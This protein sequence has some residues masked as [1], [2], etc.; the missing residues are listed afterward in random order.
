MANDN[1]NNSRINVRFAELAKKGECALI[2]YVVAGYPDL[3]TSQ[4]VAEMLI[5]GGA[6]AIEI[7][8]PFSDPI[9]DGPTIQAASNASLERG[10]R[11]IDALGLAARIRR[12][13]PSVPI[14]VMTYSNI[15]AR[16]GF[17]SF[18]D[19]SEKSGI[20]GFI[21]PDMPVEESD[22]Y[23]KAA[24]K[25]GMSTVFLASPNTTPSRLKDIVERTSG[26]LY[27]VSVFGITGAR[28]SIE[29]YS[30]QA[31]RDVKAAAGAKMPVA[32]GFGISRPD[33]VRRMR[34]AGADAVI[35]GSA[36]VDIIT[37]SV[38]TKSKM[39]RE[40]RNYARTMKSACKKSK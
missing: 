13:Y 11:P 36:L 3:P 1:Y 34:G 32:V 14:L 38:R 21:T 20:D 18:M 31:V 27:M 37:R 22:E 23:V 10:T 16:N 8:I 39:L 6:D 25:H 40:V 28:S 2:C 19:Q 5:E 12:K 17:E 4:A 7:G 33:H 26:F 29:Q 9:A 24:T 30:L 15:L 35:V